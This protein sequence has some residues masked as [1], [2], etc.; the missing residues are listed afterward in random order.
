MWR[1]N[2]LERQVEKHSMNL[3]RRTFVK[4]AATIPFLSA[5]SYSR[6]LGSNERLQIAF[7][8][9]GGMGTAHA[10]NL[11]ERVDAENVH[12][13]N[14]CDVYRRRLM[15]VAKITGGKPTLEYR[16]IIDSPDVDA[17]VVSTPDHWHTK[18]AIE[19]M[20]SGKDVYC[21]K[22]L[23]HTIEQALAC[24]D[25]VHRTGRILQVGPQGTSNP[26]YWAARKAIEADKIGKVTWSQGSYCRNSRGGQFNW[27]IDAD[28]GPN[29]DKHKEGY[30]WWDRWLGWEWDLAPKIDWNADHFFRF[31]KYL[32][33]NGG[34]ATDL[35]YH[36]LAP[37]LRA[38]EGS[39][40]A[41]PSRVVASGGTF[42]EKDERDIPDTFLMVADYPK[43]H[44]IV[45]ASVMT[46]NEG[47]PTII[48]GQHGTMF[49]DEGPKLVGQGTWEEEFKAKNDQ[50]ME[51]IL[52]LPTRRD[53]MGNFFDAI[54][55][56]EELACNVDLGCATMVGIKMAVDAL[57]YDKVLRW[58]NESEK[59]ISFSD[60][61]SPKELL[62]SMPLPMFAC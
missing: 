18:I 9:T 26:R 50:K 40:G 56:D 52:D 48:R 7:I 33:Y 49:V 60:G 58:D 55:N 16:D 41:Y 46:N 51:V 15:N 35:L 34:L 37:F 4:T 32:A 3:T 19:A 38:I 25:A 54:R 31:R 57:R 36:R 43:E 21:E 17:V 30:V 39:N 10:N 53:H 29:Q 14:V 45:L 62:A 6:V 23:S 2:F 5:A 22:P 59:V 61:K 20:E 24:R 42:L 28:A 1:R 11:A 47:L 27:P 8:G 13:T 12:I 44:S